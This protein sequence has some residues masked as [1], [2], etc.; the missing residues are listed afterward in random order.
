MKYLIS[1]VLTML[2]HPAFSQSK[3]TEQVKAALEG[4][5]KAWN[6]GQLEDAM[7]YYRD[8]PDLLWISRAGLEKGYQPIYEG[9]LKDFKDRSAMGTFTY[10][11]L[12]IEALSKRNVFYVYRWKI[13]LP[14]KKLMGGV[15]SQ[16][17]KKTGKGWK[18][19]TE[20]AS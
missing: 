3:P 19:F 7:A 10:E 4:Q 14:G 15:S 12:Y 16:I 20:H 17:W 5:I 18:I 1:V 8:S 13:A 11:P 6:S 2:I 9:Y